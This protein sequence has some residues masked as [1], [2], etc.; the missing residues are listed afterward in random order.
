MQSWDAIGEAIATATD[1]DF[2]IRDHGTVGGGCINEAAVVSDGR[3]RYF[4]KIN[5]DHSFPMFEAEAAGLSEIAAT[6]AI[7]APRPVALGTAGGHAYLVL[8]HLDFGRRGDPG[9][10]GERLAALH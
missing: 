5:A 2:R 8:E 3:R 6:G 9:R 4:V 10:L 1:S 7:R